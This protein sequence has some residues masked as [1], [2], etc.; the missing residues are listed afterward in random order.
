MAKFTKNESV[1]INEYMKDRNATRSYAIAFNRD[2]DLTCRVEG[3][4]LLTKPNVL[5]EISK[6]LDLIN[7]EARIDAIEILK[8]LKKIAFSEYSEIADPAL[9][10]E[11]SV[12]TNE[13]GFE[14]RRVKMY[15]KL[16]ALELLGKYKSM[17]VDRNEI[18]LNMTNPLL[19]KLK[20]KVVAKDTN[21]DINNNG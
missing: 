14:T 16:K 8:E 19:T 3:H 5:K 20:E 1:F 6:Q 11:T 21:S 15:D 7:K 12:T 13:K 2:K 9:V 18:N 4:K 17:F 10:Q